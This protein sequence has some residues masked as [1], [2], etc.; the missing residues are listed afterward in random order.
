MEKKKAKLSNAEKGKPGRRD[1][2]KAGLAGAALAGLTW[3]PKKSFAQTPQFKF[4]MQSF[5]P[6]GMYY[7]EV[8][9]PRFI[10]NVKE[11]SGGRIEITA[12]PPGVLVATF[13]MLD[14]VGKG[15]VDMGY[16]AQVYWMGMLPFTQWTWGVPFAFDCLDHY[17]YLWYEAGLIKLVREAFATKN[18]FFIGPI[19]SDEWGATMSKKPINSLKDF[20]GLKVRTFS[21]AGEIWKMHGAGLVRLPGDELYTG[22]ST[23]VIDA[24]NWGS[25]RGML[26]TK[27]HEVAKYFVGPPLIQQDMEDVFINMDKWKSLPPDLQAVLISAARIWHV[28]RCCTGTM[29]D[30]EAFETHKKAGVKVSNLPDKDVAEIRRLV[31][32]LWEKMAGKDDY[33]QRAVKI[34][35]D[36]IKLVEKRGERR[37][38]VK[39]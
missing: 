1:F 19:A 28:E 20:K 30:A 31:P 22:M 9:L 36:T 5:I 37:M 3:S 39:I 7:A 16:G 14:A 29:I 21:I 38:W 8:I 18:A 23:G 2:L 4:R 12:F 27:L 35:K 13:D 6:A 26:D 24:C 33:T 34:I 11:M 17:D 10:K 15:V 25:P 32:E